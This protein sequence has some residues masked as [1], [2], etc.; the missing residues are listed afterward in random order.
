[1]KAASQFRIGTKM[2]KR[3]YEFFRFI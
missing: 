3:Y 1:M 2:T